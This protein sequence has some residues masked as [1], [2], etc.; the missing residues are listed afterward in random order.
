MVLSIPLWYLD[1]PSMVPTPYLPPQTKGFPMQIPIHA[2]ATPPPSLTSGNTTTNGG[3][4]RKNDPIAPLPPWAQPPCTLCETEGHPTNICPTLLELRNIIH[5]P[6]ETTLFA[7]PP[8]TSIAT[9]ES[10]TTCNKGLQTKFACSISSEYGHY[11][12]HYPTLP[13]FCQTLVGVRQTSRPYPLSHSLLRLTLLI[14]V[15]F[16]RWSPSERVTIHNI[17]KFT[18]CLAVPRTLYTISHIHPHHLRKITLTHWQLPLS[19]PKIPCILAFFT[20]T[21]IS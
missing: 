12:H 2:P 14:F 15:I 9:T 5:L 6:K 10:S 3:R 21:K 19:P 16:H 7:T 18:L 4:Q 20:A 11:T 17:G 8:S 13:Q 1:P